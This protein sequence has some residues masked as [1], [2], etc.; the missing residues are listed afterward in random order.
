MRTCHLL[1]GGFQ[2]LGDVFRDE[3]VGLHRDEVN[4]RVGKL[5]PVD[6]TIAVGVELLD[7]R[8]RHRR[9][10]RGEFF[11]VELAVTVGIVVLDDLLCLRR[12]V[13]EP[14]VA[15][16]GGVSVDERVAE[17]R[18]RD[19][20]LSN[21]DVSVSI[22]VCRSEI[23]LPSVRLIEISIR[24]SALFFVEETVVVVV[25]L[26]EDLVHHRGGVVVARA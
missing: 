9:S 26:L 24:R 19:G 1:D 14:H 15:L 23:D 20:E 22:T 7:D 21:I 11:A 8:C 4:V 25:V 5:L 17:L 12:V 13:L 18:D 16:A 2:Q 10:R 6:V 3:T